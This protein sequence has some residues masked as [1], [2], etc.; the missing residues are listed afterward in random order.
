MEKETIMANIIKDRMTAT[1][2]DDIVVFLIGM[3]VNSWWKIHRWLPVARAMSP[4]MKEL[5]QDPQSGL[6]GATFAFT[7][8]GPLVVQYWSSVEKLMSYASDRT[9]QHYPAWTAFNRSIG[10]G[11]EVGIW[12]ET[13]SV[14]RGNYESIYVNMPA[15]GLGKVGKLEPARGH[16]ARARGRLA[17][18][19]AAPALPSAAE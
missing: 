11:G 7:S 13:Y 10:T 6:L 14:P 15:F 12:H 3:R 8:Q 2:D 17:P 9:A 5:L 1:R 18:S 4:M 16:K 19:E